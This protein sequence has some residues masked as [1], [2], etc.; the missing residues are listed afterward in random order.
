MKPTKIL[1]CALAAGAVT[2]ATSKVYALQGTVTVSGTVLLQDVNHSGFDAVKKH[3]I[4]QKDLLFILEQATGDTSITNKPTKLIYD[5]DAFNNNAWFSNQGFDFY[6][7]FY[8]SNSVSGLTNLDGID[9]SGNYF[10][11]IELDCFNGV[12]G[13]TEGFWNAGGVELNNI[14]A[15]SHNKSTGNGN[16]ILYVH[17]NPSLYNLPGHLYYANDWDGFLQQ[18][19]LVMHGTVQFTRSFSTT[20]EKESFNLSGSGDGVV[21]FENVVV[22]GKAKFSAKGLAPD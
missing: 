19:A 4:K 6:G 22:N 13:R 12:L 7:V 15:D 8:Y 11:Y 5:P 17:S 18:Y 3:S 9:E 20:T 21:D 14:F 10:S 2:F 16:A 1:M